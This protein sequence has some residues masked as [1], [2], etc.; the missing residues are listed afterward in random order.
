MTPGPVARDCTF[1]SCGILPIRVRLYP[2]AERVLGVDELADHR[3]SGWCSRAKKA[4]A[5][6]RISPGLLQLAVL[7]PE[8]ADLRRLAAGD[9][10]RVALIHL[11]PADP[12]AQRVRAHPPPASDPRRRSPAP[13]AA[14]YP[15]PRD[16]ILRQPPPGPDLIT[17]P[18]H[19]PDLRSASR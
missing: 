4:D 2:V 11:G 18:G 13:G 14:G 6:R 9:P 12:L 1:K 16:R 10:G 3:Y 17:E 19:P 8:L 15:Q 5:A 7:S